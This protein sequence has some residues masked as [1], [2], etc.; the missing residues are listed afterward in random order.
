MSF[1]T[2]A[3]AV[4]GGIL[5]GGVYALLAAGLAIIF[6]VMRVINFAQAEFMM[7]GMF[8]SYVA[9]TTLGIDPL[10]L[11]LPVGVL[12]TVFG[13]AFAWG[14]LERVPRGDNNAQLILTLGASIVMQNAILMTFGPTPRVLVRPYTNA[15]WIPWDLFINHA[16]LYA[17]LA[18]LLVMTVLYVF[19]TRTWTGRSLRATADDPTA[20]GSVGINVRYTHVAAFGLGAGLAGLA[21]TLLSTFVAAQ[22]AIGNDFIVIMF[23][24][25]VLGGLGSVGGAAL[26]AFL[27]GLVQS[28]S[29]L[30]LPLQLQNVMLFIVFVVILLV[31][32]QGLFGQRQRV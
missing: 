30:L 14:L 26:G 5:L 13:L 21:G 9:A 24:S 1:S 10:I 18:S 32:P 20:A 23:L 6:G 27:V 8:A 7:V 4:V 16:R 11:A 17:C 22:P 12:V 28:M 2:I 3:Q 29:G 31:R 19:L 25:V 15:Y